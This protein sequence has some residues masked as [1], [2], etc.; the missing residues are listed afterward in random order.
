MKRAQLRVSGMH[1]ASCVGRVESALKAVPGV[2]EA[3][4]NLLTGEAAVDFRHPLIGIV[5]GLAFAQQCLRH[6]FQAE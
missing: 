4:V 3:S 6:V 1:C 2:A 5:D